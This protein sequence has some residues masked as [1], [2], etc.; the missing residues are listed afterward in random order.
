MIPLLVPLRPPSFSK[1]KTCCVA[2][3]DYRLLFVCYRLIGPAKSRKYTIVPL[4]DFLHGWKPH[5]LAPLTFV[6]WNAQPRGLLSWNCHEEWGSPRL[7]VDLVLPC[8]HYLSRSGGGK[9]MEGH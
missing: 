1:S 5:R 7:Q 2:G 3:G 9:S 6:I 8:V 4:Q